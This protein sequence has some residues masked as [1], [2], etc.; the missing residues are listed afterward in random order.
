MNIEDINNFPFLDSP[1]KSSSIYL[2]NCTFEWL[3][4]WAAVNRGLFLLKNLGAFDSNNSLTELGMIGAT[5]PAEY[6]RE[7]NGEA[8]C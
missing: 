2:I 3:I 1:S 6:I 4:L 7:A 5:H 8:S